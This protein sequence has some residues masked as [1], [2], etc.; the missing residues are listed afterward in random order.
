MNSNLQ[1]VSFTKIQHYSNK[2]KEVLEEIKAKNNLSDDIIEYTKKIVKE[3]YGDME[4]KY[5][6]SYYEKHLLGMQ[7]LVGDAIENNKDFKIFTEI[8]ALLHDIVEDKFMTYEELEDIFSQE[9]R[10]II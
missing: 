3:R 5:G 7:E 4:R 2:I 10:H 8:I 9:V 6:G 1:Q